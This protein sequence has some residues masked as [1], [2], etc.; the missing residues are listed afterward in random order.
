MVISGEGRKAGGL[1]ESVKQEGGTG[2][3]GNVNGSPTG[4]PLDHH[5]LLLTTS[6][7]TVETS[8]SP[9]DLLS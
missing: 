5:V 9:L 2:L 3:A 7:S 4:I 1:C 8:V 6:R